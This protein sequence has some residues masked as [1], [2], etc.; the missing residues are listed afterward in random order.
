MW[1]LSLKEEQKFRLFEK[2]VLRTFE[3]KGQKAKL[4]YIM[5]SFITCTPHQI[6]G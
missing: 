3:E 5:R 1:S 2:R 4:D 6:F